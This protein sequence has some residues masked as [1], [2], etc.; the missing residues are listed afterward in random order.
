M[1]DSLGNSW[2]EANLSNNRVSELQSSGSTTLTMSGGTTFDLGSLFKTA[3]AKD[4]VFQFLLNGNSTPNTGVVVYEAAPT[5]SG[6]AG[7]Y[8][9][10]GK[11]DAADYTIWRD[12]LGQ[13]FQLENEGGIS[14][15]AVD[16][17]DYTFWKSRFGATT[18]S[19]GGSL[20]AATVPEPT[21]CGLTLILATVAA[22]V[23]RSGQQHEVNEQSEIEAFVTATWS[24]P[25]SFFGGM[26]NESS[27]MDSST[28]RSLR[29]VARGGCRD[30]RLPVPLA[31]SMTI[32]WR[33][34]DST[35]KPQS[36]ITALPNPTSPFLMQRAR[37][38]RRMPAR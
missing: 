16:A 28:N 4:L 26:T 30:R 6:V 34:L 25:F 9:K 38:S 35:R 23:A 21:S 22:A 29:V 20:V 14:P 10:D 31:S 32:A 3:G 7:D 12:H 15:G 5:I 17:A 8:N 19:G 33:A 13:S 37:W 11:V 18:G 27:E 36:S 24:V 1:Q 2:A